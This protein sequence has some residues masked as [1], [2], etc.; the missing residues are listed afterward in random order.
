WGLFTATPG[1]R[2]VWAETGHAQQQHPAG[3]QVD[4]YTTLIDRACHDAYHYKVPAT[5]AGSGPVLRS[6]VIKAVIPF[7]KKYAS[8]SLPTATRPTFANI[9]EPG[10]QGAPHHDVFD[11][12][13]ARPSLAE[14]RTGHPGPNVLQEDTSFVDQHAGSGTETAGIGTWL[15]HE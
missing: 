2:P 14:R 10:T 15:G 8:R 5:L 9:P 4:V 1:T 13:L 3:H 6:D 12:F 11:W 7:V